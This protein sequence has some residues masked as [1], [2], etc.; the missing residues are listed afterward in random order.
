ML[1]AEEGPGQIRCE[2]GVPV[3]EG[4]VFW[5]MGY[6]GTLKTG[7]PGVVDE[8][9]ELVVALEN[10]VDDGDPFRFRSDIEVAKECGRAKGR[11]DFA[12]LHI[13]Q[14]AHDYGRTLGNKG[15]CNPFP[16]SGSGS[17]DECNLTL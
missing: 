2:H 3:L 17:R 9:I 12:T 8:D 1:T 5:I 7:D 13:L 6:E 11:R 4:G 15:A 10:G 14:I 16:D